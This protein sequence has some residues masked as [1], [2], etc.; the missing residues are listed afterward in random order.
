[1]AVSII[2]GTYFFGVFLVMVFIEKN[3]GGEK[4]PTG[5]YIVFSGMSW[6]FFLMMTILVIR[7][8]KGK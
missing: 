8:W 3:K 1:M 5:H 6:V 7:N 4:I 2:A